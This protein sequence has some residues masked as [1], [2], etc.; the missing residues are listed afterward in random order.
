MEVLDG[1]CVTCFGMQQIAIKTLEAKATREGLKCVM[2]TWVQNRIRLVVES[3]AMNVIVA[4]KGALE[5]LSDINPLID[6][7]IVL[8]SSLVAV[9]FCH[10]KRDSN[11]AAHYVA[12]KLRRVLDFFL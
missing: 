5:D 4:L 10:C 3:D 7:I 8:A 9:D 2:D 1:W 6:A 12:R 11:T